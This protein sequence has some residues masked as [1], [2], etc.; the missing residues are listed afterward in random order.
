MSM[1]EECV[2]SELRNRMSACAIA[3]LLGLLVPAPGRIASA[4]E[5]QSA[6]APVASAAPAAA[7]K[8]KD[9][10]TRNFYAVLEDLLS[11]FE[12][13]LKSGQVSGL[14]DLA[15]RNVGL[16]E[17]VPES[18]K[19]HLEL[20]LTERLLKAAKV[21]MIQCL[22]CRARKTVLNGEQMVITS[23]ESNPNEMSRIARQAG[24]QNFIDVAFSYQ[25]N[26]MVLSFYI[27]EADTGSVVWS[28]S[29]NSESSRASA[30][31]RGVD[32]SQIDGMRN[33]SEYIPIVQ[34]RAIIY[35]CY[36]PNLSNYTGTL[37]AGL[38]MME[39]YDNRKKEVGFELDYFRNASSIVGATSASGT[40]LYGG[41]NI[42][43][44]FMHAWNLIGEEENFNRARG[45]IL[46]GIG[47]SYASGFLGGLIRGGYEWRLAKHWAVSGTLG[48]RPSSTYFVGGTASGS[49]SGVESAFGISALF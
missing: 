35:Y 25:P 15:V 29:Y 13:D 36:Q 1:E 20:V 18:F 14:R 10:A 2:L 28:R 32:Q 44:L 3:M 34:Y 27:T 46:A 48:Y 22:A 8:K 17:M 40:D 11:D 23:P 41:V 26:G 16:S 42:T 49:V 4:A 12:Y 5:T 43:L 37:G 47:G 38:R 24:I 19:S 7:P 21:R 33:A 31:R 6:T 39:R 45:S 30:Y 9:D